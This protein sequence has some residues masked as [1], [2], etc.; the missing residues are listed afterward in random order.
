[1]SRTFMIHVEEAVFPYVCSPQSE[2]KIDEQFHY[3]SVRS[4]MLINQDLSEFNN[5]FSNCFIVTCVYACFVKKCKYVGQ[6]LKCYN[7]V[8]CS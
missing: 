6:T 4:F 7:T 1:M 5:I 8:L 3:L 2:E